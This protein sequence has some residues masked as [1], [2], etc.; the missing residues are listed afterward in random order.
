MLERLYEICGTMRVLVIDDEENIVNVVSAVLRD[1][2][3]KTIWTAADGNAGLDIFRQ[4]R[5]QVDLI[6]C[7]WMMPGMNGLEFLGRIREIDSSVLFLMLTAKATPEAITSAKVSG[8]NAYVMKP[9]DPLDLR[10][11]V[12]AL[13]KSRH[14]EPQ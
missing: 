12:L 8:V 11:K 1:L 4:V 9:F 13:V 3:V 7:D 5:N 10:K 6:I 2:K 14:P